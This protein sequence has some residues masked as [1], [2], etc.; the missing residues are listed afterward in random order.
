MGA[1]SSVHNNTKINQEFLIMIN[2]VSS[3]RFYVAPI[4]NSLKSL[5]KLY[6]DE[7]YQLVINDI[8]ETIQKINDIG[9]ETLFFQELNVFKNC[10]KRLEKI[11]YRLNYMIETSRIKQ[12]KE[13]K[14]EN[15]DLKKKLSELERDNFKLQ[16]QFP[17]ERNPFS[18]QILINSNTPSAPPL[19]DE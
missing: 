2:E 12:I 13:Y 11:S 9:K 8:P 16:N 19:F 15:Q 7:K 1:N 17:P 5:K 10:V 3:S 6:N 4:L 18:N 14:K